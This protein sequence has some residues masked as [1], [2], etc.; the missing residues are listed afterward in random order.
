MFRLA[1][2]SRSLA[3]ILSD[4]RWL[5]SLLAIGLLVALGWKSGSHV[6][7]GRY[8]IRYA[9][10]L[11]TYIASAAL[12][13]GALTRV[14]RGSES[15]R[16]ALRF[17]VLFFPAVLWLP[18][19]LI[20]MAKPDLASQFRFYN[21]L[22]SLVVVELAT[23]A[24]VAAIVGGVCLLFVRL[25]DRDLRS[26][27][28][29]WWNS[30]AV[31]MSSVT[32]VGLGYAAPASL[33]LWSINVAVVV[34]LLGPRI[35]GREAWWVVALPLPWGVVILLIARLRN[36]SEFLAGATAALVAGALWLFSH[37]RGWSLKTA[38]AL[39]LLPTLGL[40]M[41]PVVLSHAPSRPKAPLIAGDPGERPNVL[42]L[43]IDTLRAD[44]TALGGYDIP[45]TPALAAL[46][47]A[48]ATVF[49]QAWSPATAT[50]PSIKALFTA[51]PAS[52]WGIAGAGDRPPPAGETTLP[53]AFRQAGY[54]TAGFSANNLVGDPGFAAGFDVFH[55]F[56]G[57]QYLREQ[58]L[59]AGLVCQLDPL[60]LFRL[61]E[62]RH[63]HKLAGRD[64]VAC[65]EDWLARGNR[66]SRPFFMYLHIVEPHWPY[67]DEGFG[68]LER[69]RLRPLGEPSLSHVDLIQSSHASLARWRGTRALRELITRY[70][71]GVRRG[72]DVLGAVTE[73]LE[74]TGVDENTLL[75]VI[76]DHGEEFLEHG[77][78]SHGHDV[79][80]ELAHVPFLVRW[81]DQPRFKR[82]PSRV[83]Q[84]VS[85]AS[86]FPTLAEL[87]DLPMRPQGYFTTLT[88]LLRGE[89]DASPVLTEG[90]PPGGFAV[91]WRQSSTYVRVGWP[92]LDWSLEPTS[93]A[94]FTVG[95]YDASSGEETRPPNS[96]ES[97]EALASVLAVRARGNGD[98]PAASAGPRMESQSLEQLRA[99]GYLK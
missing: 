82:M 71:E 8:S 81:P 52:A 69:A 44:H 43:V 68:F 99:L 27:E 98:G 58:P 62:R 25:I 9:C 32:L 55:V 96:A 1:T 28:A 87:L 94:G 2:L 70:D 21:V 47:G 33:L 95:F 66:P 48:S 39:G 67:Y 56:S 80:R 40:G 35:F 83:K 30:A 85:V 20:Q 51:K 90:F 54:Q 16:S 19:A 73:L 23:A 79:H 76:G 57:L 41:M 74:R 3:R 38:V 12:C 36:R 50:L 6:V 13:L 22:H 34:R 86:L 53:V 65:A 60:C 91:A 49:E 89:R 37:T 88:P 42:L 75:V 59:S 93:P 63:H 17:Q 72:D 14:R 77:G 7:L 97:A 31:A 24:A 26:E 15:A 11:V 92:R 78:F 64:V 4:P 10:L 84:P 45:T 5:A 29:L 46:A 61:A 18:F